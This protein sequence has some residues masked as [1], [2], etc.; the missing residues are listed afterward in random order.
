MDLGEGVIPELFSEDSFGVLESYLI[1]G[2]GW[3]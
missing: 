1:L 2:A 3:Y